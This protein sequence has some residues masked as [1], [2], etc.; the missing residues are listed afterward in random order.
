[1]ARTVPPGSC[2]SPRPT[3]PS[4]RA[5]PAALPPAAA[6][7]AASAARSSVP[8]ASRR[9]KRRSAIARATAVHGAVG[10]AAH[11]GV[12]TDA[13]RHA[14]RDPVAPQDAPREIGQQ[15]L[16]A[17]ALV[18]QRL[19]DHVAQLADVARPRVRAQRRQRG[20]RRALDL[21]P[22]RRV[23]LLAVESL[24]K[25]GHQRRQV[26]DPLAQRRHPDRHDRQALVKVGAEAAV[27][28]ERTEIAV[29]GGQDP[30]VDDV[31]RVLADAA[32]H[33]V[34]QHPEQLHLERQ[35]R[36]VDLVEK[37]GPTLGRRQLSLVGA[38][39]TGERAL[40]VTEHLGF[41]QLVRDRGAVDRDEPAR[42]PRRPFVQQAGRDLLARAG[43][44]RQQHRH[45]RPRGLRH[46]TQHG[47]RRIAGGHEPIRHGHRRLDRR[48]LGDALGE[49][50]DRARLARVD[51][52]VRTARHGRGRVARRHAAGH[53][54][55]PR[56]TVRRTV[57]G[58]RARTASRGRGYDLGHDR[59]F[60]PLGDADATAAQLLDELRVGRAPRPQHGRHRR[61]VTRSQRCSSGASFR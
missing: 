12:P 27:G 22:R 56:H 20:R 4:N 10:G 26:C 33:P 21:V 50:R 30:E 48:Q 17:G 29:G 61:I 7:A 47:P 40:R 57:A 38:H 35:R 60:S 11:R 44:A 3:R 19:E 23:R 28:A 51:D 14:T 2:A 31:R 1:M 43:L 49:A 39:R 41:D 36:V 53:E 18:H 59:R 55:D 45:R 24:R 32:D 16:A 15:Q 58:A 9:S 34:L 54:P 13:R 46:L 6:S 52:V 42:A 5:A 8:T 37:H 25:V